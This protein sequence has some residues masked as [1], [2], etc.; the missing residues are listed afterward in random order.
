MIC[1]TRYQ[2]FN[3]SAQPCTGIV[4]MKKV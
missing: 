2:Q 1:N 4:F 3:F